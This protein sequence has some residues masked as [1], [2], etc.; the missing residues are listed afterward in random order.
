MLFTK[1]KRVFIMKNYTINKALEILSIGRTKFYQELN[2][3]RIKALKVGK[4]TLVTQESIDN[5]LKSL[6]SYKSCGGQ[7]NDK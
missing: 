4:R 3:G 5:W 2:A 1:Q 6:P 7:A